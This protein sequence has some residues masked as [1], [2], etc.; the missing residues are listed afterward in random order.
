MN[1]L[2]A[3]ADYFNGIPSV[4][5]DGLLY[6]MIGVLAFLL[7]VFS[8]DDAAKYIEAET[9]FWTKVWIGGT[10]AAVVAAKMFRSTQFAEH[11]AYKEEE[12]KKTGHTDRWVKSDTGP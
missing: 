11:R 2:K 7:A 3:I 12:R 8:S 4:F 9:L 5:I 10:N 1:T 6:V